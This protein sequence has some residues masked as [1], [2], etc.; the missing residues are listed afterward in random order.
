VNWLT[1]FFHTVTSSKGIESLV[2]EGGIYALAAIIFSENALL[3]G[4]FLPGDS[5]LITAGILIG[6]KRVDINF[7]VLAVVLCVAAIIGESV[8]YFIGKKAGQTLYRRPNSRFFKR[9]HLMRTHHF[10]EKHGGKTI[11][12]ARFIPIIRTFVPVVAGAA[13]MDLKKFTIFNIVGGI[14]WIFAGLLA[15]LILGQ[16]VDNIGDYLYLV[17]GIVIFLSAL[18]PIIEYF[19]H[20]ANVKAALLQENGANHLMKK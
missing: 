5:L 11:I 12:L 2:T 10:Y 7:L 14:V 13:G 3:V 8:G 4:F 18:P 15:G 16:T 9:E 19:R 17:I 20:R 6:S 1:D